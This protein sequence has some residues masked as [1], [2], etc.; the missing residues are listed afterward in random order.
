MLHVIF[1]ISCGQM[2]LLFFFFIIEA[3]SAIYNQL[4]KLRERIRWLI[5]IYTTYLIIWRLNYRI[6]HIKDDIFSA[7]PVFHSTP[8]PSTSLSLAQ[9]QNIGKG[10]HTSSYR[11]QLLD[12]DN[13][14]D[15]KDFIT[16]FMWLLRHCFFV[17]GHD[18]FEGNMTWTW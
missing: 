12:M 16:L 14:R 13:P 3:F 10:D 7:L 5:I 18:F 4:L 11:K 15:I 8:H 9:K 1:P 6:F 17:L 2:R